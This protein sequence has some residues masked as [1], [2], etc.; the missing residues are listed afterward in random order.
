MAI[1][2]RRC[3]LRGGERRRYPMPMHLPN[4]AAIDAPSVLTWYDRHARDLPWRIPPADRAKG[5][6]PDPYRVWLSEVMLQ[7]TTVAAVR[8]YFIRFISLWPTVFDLA[9]A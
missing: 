3:P 8:N 2:D 6:R 7:Q 9:A 1:Q 5:I 4:P